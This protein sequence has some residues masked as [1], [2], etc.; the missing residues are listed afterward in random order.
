MTRRISTRWVVV[1]FFVLGALV[2]LLLI[3]RDLGDTDVPEEEG[4]APAVTG[5]R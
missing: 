5:T 1:A 3:V 2:A 4:T